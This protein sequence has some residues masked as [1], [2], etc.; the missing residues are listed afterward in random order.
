MGQLSK[1]ALRAQR[2][3]ARAQQM[4][5]TLSGSNLLNISM[6]NAAI[7]QQ[8]HRGA[9]PNHPG[10]QHHFQYAMGESYLPLGYDRE[11]KPIPYG[12]PA[13]YPGHPP[14]PPHPHEPGMNATDMYRLPPIDNMGLGYDPTAP[15]QQGDPAEYWAT[16]PGP[17]GAGYNH[18]VDETPGGPPPERYYAPTPL[19]YEMAPD[20]TSMSS[21]SYQLAP[22]LDPLAAHPPP[23]PPLPHMHGAKEKGDPRLHE[24]AKDGQQT[25]SGH[26]TFNERLFDGAVGIP[27]LAPL[28]GG[29]AAARDDGL[30]G[31]DE[32][33]AQVSESGHW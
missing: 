4:R 32:A 19:G 15:W 13:A 17:P 14:A 3:Q 29:E 18:N 9:V 8:Q 30:A 10:A 7:Q 28:E 12:S 31:F 5:Q 16:V 33:M 21:G 23:P 24:W 20:P 1:G 2:A 25:P 27:G 26:V 6:Y 11:G 22:L